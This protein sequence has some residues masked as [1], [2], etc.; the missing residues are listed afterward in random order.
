M[1]IFTFLIQLIVLLGIIY[2]AIKTQKSF[3]ES[4]EKLFSKSESEKLDTMWKSIYEIEHNRLSHWFA[5]LA[6]LLSLITIVLPIANWLW[7]KESKDDF[8]YLRNSAAKSVDDIEKK[9]ESIEKRYNEMDELYMRIQESEKEIKL[10]NTATLSYRLYAGEFTMDRLIYIL[11]DKGN[12]EKIIDLLEP[13]DHKNVPDELREKVYF[14]LGISY[15]NMGYYQK[16]IDTF[17]ES[18]KLHPKS[19]NTQKNL[20]EAYKK[21]GGFLEEN[22][23]IKDAVIQYENAIKFDSKN[24]ELKNKIELLKRP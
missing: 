20:S 11:R 7:I 4:T 23:K 5:A 3:L 14:D 1:N 15:V 17:Y 22:G 12:W 24:L 18:L 16:G 2:I 19:E 9:K 8:I 10:L 6:I 21:Y 13:L